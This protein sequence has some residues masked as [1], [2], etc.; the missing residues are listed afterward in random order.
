VQKS[1]SAEAVEFTR[2]TR[3]Y[4]FVF[5][6]LQVQTHLENPTKY[7]IQQAQRQQV[8]Q[9]LST[10][11][12]NKHTNQALS[13]PCPNQPGDH[14]MPPGAGSSAPNSPMAMLTLNSNCEKEGFYKFDEQG[15]RVENE[16]QTLNTHPRASCMQMDDV[17]DDIISLES[18]Y[19]EEIFGLM[20]PALQMANT[21]L[22]FTLALSV[23]L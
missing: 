4:Y 8:K 22:Q 14:V 10:T 9:Y 16:C 11:L 19:N 7:H 12:A 20:D 15:S 2:L 18:S 3:C 5:M 23:Y 21:V 13:L 6:C 17:I 1:V